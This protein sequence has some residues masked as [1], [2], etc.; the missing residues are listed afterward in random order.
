MILWCLNFPIFPPVLTLFNKYFHTYHVFLTA[1]IYVTESKE[2]KDRVPAFQLF[3]VSLERQEVTI[4][5]L[6]LR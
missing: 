5:M 1:I 2:T 6:T 3:I 4:C